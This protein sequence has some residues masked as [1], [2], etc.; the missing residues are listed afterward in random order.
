[1]VP[2]LLLK[3]LWVGDAAGVEDCVKVHVNQVVKVLRV[4]GKQ[5]WT[6]DTVSDSQS[7]IPFIMCQGL[8]V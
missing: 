6:S 5:A 3:G 1:M 4:K 7:K 2:A 8:S